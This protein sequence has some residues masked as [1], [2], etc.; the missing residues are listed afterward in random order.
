MAVNVKNMLEVVG[1]GRV[2][3][4]GSFAPNGGSA[5]SAASNRGAGFSVARAAAGQYT[6]TF[7]ERFPECEAATATVQLNSAAAGAVALLG[8]I[9]LTARTMLITVF[10]ESAGTLAVSDIA[11][12]AN[13]RINFIVIF[14][15][16]T[17]PKA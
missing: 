3:V 10:T 12:N 2:V 16:S 5:I 15:R 14:K 8:P 9:D 13:N 4:A 1:V 7:N 6:V 11:A 17:A